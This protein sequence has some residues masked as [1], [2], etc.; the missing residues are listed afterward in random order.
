MRGEPK[1]GRRSRC[2]LAALVV[3]GTLGAAGASA[4]AAQVTSGPFP[5][6]FLST[7][8]TM[9]KG[10]SLTLFNIDLLA[11]HNVFS[12]KSR[13]G[14]RLFQSDTI[15][16]FEETPVRRASR[17]RRGSYPFI[18]SIHPFMRGTLRVN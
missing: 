4:E 14:K 16:A 3:A 8:V 13:R 2:A 12:V 6:A 15:G 7:N 10:E 5:N 9:A 11:P 17:L 1:R 18:C